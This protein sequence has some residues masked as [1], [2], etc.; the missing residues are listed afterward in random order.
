MSKKEA[1]EDLDETPMPVKKANTETSRM[2]ETAQ[3]KRKG[4]R[5]VK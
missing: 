2:D 3:A 4:T 5:K 1:A